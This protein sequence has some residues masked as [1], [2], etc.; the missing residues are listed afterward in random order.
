M[1]CYQEITYQDCGINA[2]MKSGQQCWG[3]TALPLYNPWLYG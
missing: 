3:L 2:I 1:A